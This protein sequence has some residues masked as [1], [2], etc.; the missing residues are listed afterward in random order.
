MA[1]QTKKPGVSRRERQAIIRGL[2]FVS[3]WLVGLLWFYVYP[4]FASLYYSFHNTTPF[5]T[6]AFTGLEN[7]RLLLG[8]PLFWKSLLNTFYYTGVAVVLGN[9]FA[10]SLALL[11]SQ[12]LRGMTFYRTIFYLP[13]IVPFVAVSVVWIWILHPQYGIVNYAL[14]W[15]GL[16][17]LGWFSDPLWA[18][19]G[20]IIVSLWGTGN[21]MIIYLAGLLDIPKELHEAATIDGATAWQ[22]TL[23]ITIPLLTP[24]ILFNV[25]IGLI[26]GFQYF[27]QPYIITGGGP[28]DAT[29]VYALYLYQNAFSYF[30]MGYASAMAWV[31][32]VVIMIVTLLVFRSSGRWVFYRR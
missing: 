14:E 17:T 2:L 10:L 22:R 6:G 18:M 11:L 13:S 21:M 23:R 7:Y 16:P 4:F 32:F 26:G 27:V 5:A 15:L 24:I 8:D 31:L 28:A 1:I 29:L 20:L 12:N 25:V 19:P 9:L 30:R 3:P